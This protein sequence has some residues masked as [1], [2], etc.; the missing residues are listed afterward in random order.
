M[1]ELRNIDLNLLVIFQRLLQ[2][3]SIS[4]VARQ[5]D[6]SQPAVSNA[7]RRLRAACGDDLFVRTAQG[8]QP[9]PHAERLGGPVG[10][11]LALLS[12]ALDATQDFEPRASTRRF[13]IAM[14]DVGEIHFMPRLMDQCAR[15]APGVRI[16]SLRLQGADLQREMDAG[17]VDLAI[18][19]FAD[20][21]GAVMQRMLF[22]QGYATLYRQGHP[23]AHE[24]MS[25]KAFRAAHH[26]VVSHATPYG[27][28][29]QS[30]ERAGV[31]LGEHFSVPHFAAVPYIVSTTDLLATVPQKLAAS[32]APHFGLGLLTPPLRMPTLQTNLYWH[33]RF[34][35][36]SGSQWLRALIV[37][38]FA[39]AP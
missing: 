2:E 11:A 25:L 12:H 17:R 32:A 29:N 34:Q 4:A 9:T 16:D 22:R 15:H 21:G 23:S 10:E 8:M 19:A 24:G 14:S 3:R 33:R 26:L 38:A 5:L 13:R 28:V 18:G 39:D 7:L 31:T 36:D 27:Q 37:Q 35:R 20:L 1:A 30:L 6:L